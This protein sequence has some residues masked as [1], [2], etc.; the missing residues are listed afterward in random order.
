MVPKPTRLRKTNTVMQRINVEWYNRYCGSNGITKTR[1][2][3]PG[4]R[5]RQGGALTATEMV[6]QWWN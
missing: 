5:M 6:E 4:D 3:R 1:K 2:V